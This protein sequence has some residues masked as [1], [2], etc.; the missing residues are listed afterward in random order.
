MQSYLDATNVAVTDNGTRSS[1][2][3]LISN[4][5][6]DQTTTFETLQSENE[7]VD[8][9]EVAIQLS[10]SELTYEASL[11]ATSK[12]MQTTLMNYI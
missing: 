9:S 7:D 12:I 8:I 2:L 3:E 1:R 10:S 11:M 6:M 5:L 4:R